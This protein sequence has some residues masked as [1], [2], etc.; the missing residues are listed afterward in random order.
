MAQILQGGQPVLNVINGN[1]TL[2]HL[3]YAAREHFKT[4][5]GFF[6]TFVGGTDNDGRPRPPSSLWCPREMPLQFMYDEG[7][8]IEIKM[9]IVEIYQ[10]AMADPIG[11]II[12]PSDDVKYQLPFLLPER[13]KP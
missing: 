8:P 3:Q 9:E 13:P 11:V 6:L 2:A 10:H 1:F 5:D 12:G 7:S 4:G